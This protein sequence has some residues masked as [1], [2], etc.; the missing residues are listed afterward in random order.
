MSGFN[1]SGGLCGRWG[2]GSVGDG[3][4]GPGSASTGCPLPGPVPQLPRAPAQSL[5]V[6]QP[7][8]PQGC[9]PEAPVRAPAVCS[10]LLPGG[11]PRKRAGPALESGLWGSASEGARAGKP[12]VHWSHV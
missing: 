9:C 10:L 12:L 7:S 11:K 3:A 5:P 1:R 8:H 4:S 6:K 2:R